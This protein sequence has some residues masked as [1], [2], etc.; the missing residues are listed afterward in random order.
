MHRVTR[1]PWLWNERAV[2]CPWFRP[3]LRQDT[4]HSDQTGAKI[5]PSTSIY[6]NEITSGLSNPSRNWHRF[7]FHPWLE[8]G[9][10]SLWNS[11]DVSSDP[12][13]GLHSSP[14]YALSRFPRKMTG[15]WRLQHCGATRVEAFDKSDMVNTQ[16]LKVRCSS[17]RSRF[18][19][20]YTLTEAPQKSGCALFR[21]GEPCW[22]CWPSMGLVFSIVSILMLLYLMLMMSLDCT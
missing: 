17:M 7:A 12:Q 13:T 21:T 4:L 6:K 14:W 15:T 3:K 11:L 18:T 20:I 1:Q 8:I 5:I 2:K 10:L 16:I 22:I 9:P 19:N